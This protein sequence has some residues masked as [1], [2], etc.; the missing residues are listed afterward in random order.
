MS[1][2]LRHSVA[3]CKRNAPTI[4]TWM[5]GIGVAATVITAVKAT[6][7]ALVKLDE[8][9]EEKGAELTKFEIV[10]AVGPIYVPTITTGA[11]TIACIF[12]ANLLN[13]R[14]QAS[15]ISAYALLENTYKGYKDKV[16]ELYGKETDAKVKEEVAKD[17]YKETD[18]KVE[19][20]K[21]LF[22]DE[23]SGRYFESTIETVQ[24]AQ[25]H[26]NRDLIMRDYATLNEYYAYLGIDG[27]D[28]GD[29][30][31]WSTCMNF[32]AYWQVWI[33]FGH[34]KTVMDDG[35]ECHVITMFE[36]PALGWDDYA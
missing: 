31:G 23:F 3:V 26:I 28:G 36:E 18:I 7:K 2:F 14:K 20:D 11:A 17:K 30:L 16:V 6:P 9:K 29:E 8:V 1:S 12:G 33:D 27:I 13:K 32:D 25:Y 34:H 4:L 35:L 19:K 24:S 15:L 21:E 10:K 5:G 22:Y